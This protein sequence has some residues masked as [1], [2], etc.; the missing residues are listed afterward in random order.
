M[1]AVLLPQ[2]FFFYLLH[3]VFAPVFS[4]T[5]VLFRQGQDFL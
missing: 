3:R 4:L 1:M 2:R 5:G